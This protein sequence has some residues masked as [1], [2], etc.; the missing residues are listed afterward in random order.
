MNDFMGR[1]MTD[2]QMGC[3]LINGHAPNHQKHVTGMFNIVG[4][5]AGGRQ[6]ASFIF[7]TKPSSH[8]H[9]NEIKHVSKLCLQSKMDGYLP[10]IQFKP[11]KN[12]SQ[13][14][15]LPLCIWQAQQP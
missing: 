8:R 7:S 13:H 1:T 14:T 3:Y 6:L 11:T 4:S 12:Q 15:A 2:M 10:L 5:T 9:F